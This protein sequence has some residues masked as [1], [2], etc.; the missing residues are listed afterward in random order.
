VTWSQSDLVHFVRIGLSTMGRAKFAQQFLID[1]TTIPSLFKTM[2]EHV[3]KVAVLGAT[4]QQGGAVAEA[5]AKKGI[6]VIAITRNVSSEKAIALASRAH[7]EVRE[8]DLNDKDSLVKAFDGCDGAFVIANFWEGMDV[9]KEVQHYKNATDALKEVGSMKHIVYSTLDETTIPISGHFKTLHECEHEDAKGPMKVPHFDG[10][11][12]CEKMFEG[13]PATFMITSFYLE[14]FC[15]YFAFTKGEDGSYTFTLPLSDVKLPYTILV[16]LGELAA[17]AFT[18]PE[19]IGQKIGQASLLASGDD[20]AEI[21]SKATGKTI[22]YNCVP[23]ETFASFGFP[24]AE[25]LAQ[26]FEFAI[27][28]LDDFTKVRDMD[29]QTKIMDGKKFT[30][31]VEYSK[32]IPLKFE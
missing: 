14:N 2:H 21:F 29:A 9:E 11:A 5:L 15:T 31:A 10:K 18:K 32:T 24:G 19:L 7:T 27:L 17:G 23:W 8:A 16:D 28:T 26:M 20:L 6:E 30:D 13:L 4:G 3:T 12:R 25:E 22:K 1:S